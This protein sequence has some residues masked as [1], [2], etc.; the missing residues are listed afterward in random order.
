[1]QAEHESARARSATGTCAHI[2][3]PDERPSTRTE[4]AI[5]VTKTTSA[6][7]PFG[8]GQRSAANG[9]LAGHSVLH[10][11]ST[12]RQICARCLAACES[13]EEMPGAGYAFELMFPA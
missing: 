12:E 4:P 13:G 6:Y 3:A 1:V 9:V 7:V 11:L 2:T 5:C 10:S 8:A